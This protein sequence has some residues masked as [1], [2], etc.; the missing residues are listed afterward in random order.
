MRFKDAWLWAATALLSA[1]GG[2]VQDGVVQFLG[3]APNSAKQL[4]HDVRSVKTSCPG[5]GRS[6]ELGT[7]RCPDRKGCDARV[8]WANAYRCG[9]C[10]GSGACQACFLMEQP[11]GKCFN[12]K[13]TGYITYLGKSPPCP[14]CAGGKD[15]KP[16][17]CPV[18]KGTR[19]CDFCRG[20]G[21]VPAETVKERAAKAAA[22]DEEAPAEPAP[23]APAEEKKPEGEKKEP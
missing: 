11:D 17:F 21:K 20:E 15:P 3:P 10:R 19:K 16:G 9:Y 22:S 6:L 7:E 12:C 13:G 18:C 5:C 14:N 2:G 8:R 23:A 1:C 4:A